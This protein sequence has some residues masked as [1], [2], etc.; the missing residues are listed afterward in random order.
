MLFSSLDYTFPPPSYLF[1]ISY[2]FSVR[3]MLISEQRNIYWIYTAN[4]CSLQKD[5]RSPSTHKFCRNNKWD[6]PALHPTKL[7][8]PLTSQTSSVN[9]NTCS[10]TQWRVFAA[11]NP[12]MP[13]PF[14]YLW[15][16]ISV[17][18]Y[19]IIDIA[20]FEESAVMT[21]K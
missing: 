1:I 21:P 4:N 6:V 5:R 3:A 13:K 7:C 14:N 18:S 19:P 10:N 9:R 16:L 11:Q 8:K 17:Q 20:A 15:Y 12:N 2:P